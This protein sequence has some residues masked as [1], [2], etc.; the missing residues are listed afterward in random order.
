MT[1]I[2]STSTAAAYL[3]VVGVKASQDA[4]SNSQIIANGESLIFS[5]T[6]AILILIYFA[7]IR[8]RR[9]NK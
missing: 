2:E 1:M 6:I 5:I 7:I 3:V 9:K 8:K 4:T